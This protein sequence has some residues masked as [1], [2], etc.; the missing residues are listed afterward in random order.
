MGIAKEI[1][2]KIIDNWFKNIINEKNLTSTNIKRALT[3]DKK[4]TAQ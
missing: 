4:K 2:N 1:I 3:N